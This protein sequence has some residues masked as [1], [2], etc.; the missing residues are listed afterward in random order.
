MSTPPL[1]PT[2]F[3]EPRATRFPS[4]STRVS[5][6]SKPAQIELHGAVPAIAHVQVGGSARLLR[7]KSCQV[8]CIADAQLFNVCRTIR[9]HWIGTGLFGG[10]N[11][12]ASDDDSFHFTRCACCHLRGRNRLSGNLGS[13]QQIN[14]ESGEGRY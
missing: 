5:L 12:R 6:A 13:E 9:V 2:A 4:T 8:R 14:A 7:Q 1:N 11:V 3:N 10:R